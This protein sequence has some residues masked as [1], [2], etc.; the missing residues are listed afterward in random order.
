MQTDAAPALKPAVDVWR[1]AADAS[2]SP[3]PCED[4]DCKDCQAAAAVIE[5]D[6][7]AII[8]AK[9]AEIVALKDA[10]QKQFDE[11]VKERNEAKLWFEKAQEWKQ[12]LTA[13]Q[14]HA[15]AMAGALETAKQCEA[16]SFWGADAEKYARA[17]RRG[18]F[19]KITKA[20][21]AYEEF[22]RG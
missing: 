21:R 14:A 19:R 11:K 12:S 4:A 7:A 9:D 6:R 5:A 20:L 10:W 22:R 1:E 17:A 16:S 3:V 2:N 8:A 13:L 15:D 18:A